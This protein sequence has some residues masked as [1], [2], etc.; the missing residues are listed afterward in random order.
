MFRTK[1]CGITSPAD[2]QLLA[3]LDCDAVGLNFYEPSKRFVSPQ[4]AAR[5]AAELAPQQERVGVFVN[6]SYDFIEQVVDQVALDLIQ[7]HGDEPPSFLSGLP[8]LPIVRAFRCQ[9]SLAPVQEYLAACT[10][11]PDAVLVDA[12]DPHE[13]GGTGK[14]LH[15]PDLAQQR[16]CLGGLPLIL[17]GGLTADNVASAIELSGADAVDTASGVES[18]P[19]TKDPRKCRA[20]LRAALHGLFQSVVGSHIKA[21]VLY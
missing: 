5:I 2:A 11:K 10:R 9:E 21:A 16:D 13:Y 20:F 19:G 6:A 15:W 17:A 14:T 7:L 18:G 4:V 8:N 12:Y 1:I 3:G